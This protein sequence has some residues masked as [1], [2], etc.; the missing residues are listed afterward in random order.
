[1]L[2]IR[3]IYVW[4]EAYLLINMYYAFNM[5]IKAAADMLANGIVEIVRHWTGQQLC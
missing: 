2:V 3:F 5:N 1:M 4:I